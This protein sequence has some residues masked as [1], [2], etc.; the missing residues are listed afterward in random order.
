MC[1][2]MLGA[3]VLGGLAACKKDKT[4][5]I[6]DTRNIDD[7]EYTAA[8]IG[9]TDALGN[10]TE[11]GSVRLENRDVGLFYFLWLGAHASGIYDV[12]DL[13]ENNPDALWSVDDPASPVNAYHFWGE[14]LYGYYNSSDPWVL[15]RHVELF[16]AAGIDFLVFDTTNAVIYDGVVK[17]LLR[18]LDKYQR[19]GFDVP[20]VAFM[21]NSSSRNTVVSIYNYFYADNALDRYPDLWYSPSGKPMIIGDETKFD[22]N[23]AADKACLEFFD[24]RAAQWPDAFVQDEERFPWMSWFY[25][26]NNHNGVMSV[27]VAQH[28]AGRMS[29]QDSN[30]GRGYSQKLFENDGEGALVGVNYQF[31]WDTVFAANASSKAADVSTVFITGWNEWIAIKFKE[32]AKGVY[33]VDL[34]N[35]EYSRDLE[36]MKDGY[37]DNYYLQTGRNAKKYRY[38]AAKPYKLAVNSPASADDTAWESVRGY[39]D[40]E[41][42]AMERDY[43]GYI[44]SVR[45]ADETNRN[46]IVETKVTHDKNNLYIRVQTAEDISAYADDDEGWMNIWLATEKNGG[47]DFVINREYGKLSKLSNGVYVAVADAAVT[48][49]GKVMTVTVPLSALGQSDKPAL[50]IRVSDNVDASDRMNF[51]IQGDSAPIGEQGYTYGYFK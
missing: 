23:V 33:F 16:V 27:S 28:V 1:L 14:P 26:Q 15:T 37:G 46:D 50:R 39:K 24:M 18:I 47:F 22:E 8:S 42:D 43:R 17:E 10:V 9:G 3:V 48:A 36:M 30:W 21:T 5:Y 32:G 41:G 34:F 13:L 20:K 35:M 25:P 45:Y 19:Q 38:E 31:Q 51:Y 44:N 6:D 4:V 11:A 29:L 49:E 12:D 40:F 7:F 2:S